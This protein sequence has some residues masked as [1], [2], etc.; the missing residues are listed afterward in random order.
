ML[1]FTNANEVFDVYALYPHE[2]H[3]IQQYL[4]G[5]FLIEAG[6][7]KILEDHEGMLKRML[8]NGPVQESLRQ[9]NSLATSSYSRVV[10]E[11]EVQEGKK[12]DLGESQEADQPQ[13]QEPQEFVQNPEG[14]TGDS[15]DMQTP[16]PV[17]D[18]L[19]TGMTQPQVLEIKGEEVFM[20]GFHLSQAAAQYIL[21]LVQSGV[22]RLRY[23]RVD[24][25]NAPLVVK[26]G[27]TKS[28]F[29]VAEGIA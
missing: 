11:S 12:I 24:N 4:L 16:P 3:G 14:A 27:M 29:D 6:N 22:A 2:K 9:L 1:D 13:L 28:A 25:N 5:R 15:F 23:R 21:R 18:Y 8:K 17:F 26:E 10:P 7:L 19:R 20:N